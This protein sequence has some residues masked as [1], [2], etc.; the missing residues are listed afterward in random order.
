MRLSGS[1][2]PPL[3]ALGG[4]GAVAPDPPPLFIHPIHYNKTIVTFLR[5]SNTVQC[6]Q[7]QLLGRSPLQYPPLGASATVKQQSAGKRGRSHGD[8]PTA[9][10][11]VPPRRRQLHPYELAAQQRLV[12]IRSDVFLVV[13]HTQ[14][15]PSTTFFTKELTGLYS[16]VVDFSALVHKKSS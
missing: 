12:A 16:I 2:Q 9:S 15:T 4:A 8:A 10:S 7:R 11:A 6:P 3:A 5:D 14:T 13:L 1:T